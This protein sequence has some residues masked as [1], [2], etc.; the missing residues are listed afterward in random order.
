MDAPFTSASTAPSTACDTNCNAA[1]GLL[2]WFWSKVLPISCAAYGANAL[3]A[4]WPAPWPETPP[5]NAVVTAC[6][7]RL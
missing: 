4:T 3:L 5:T 7:A 2:P 6:N 1:F